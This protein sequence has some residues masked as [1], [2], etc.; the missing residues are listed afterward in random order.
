LFLRDNLRIFGRILLFSFA[1]VVSAARSD[2][3]MGLGYAPAPGKY[4]GRDSDKGLLNAAY[5][6]KGNHCYLC[7][8]VRLDMMDFL[9]RLELASAICIF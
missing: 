3:N 7:W 5:K 6:R 8:F 4:A 1:S 9:P 2:S